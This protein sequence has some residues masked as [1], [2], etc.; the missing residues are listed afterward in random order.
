MN[1]PELLAPIQEFA[2]HRMNSIASSAIHRIQRVN[3]SGAQGGDYDLRT[4]WNEFSWEIQNGDGDFVGGLVEDLVI[5][6]IEGV[7]EQLPDPEA[8]LLTCAFSDDADDVNY[9]DNSVIAAAVLER[10]SDKASLR[11]LERFDP[12]YLW[13]ENL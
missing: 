1:E 3:A 13:Y 2:R 10:V 6:I 9:R 7:V 4:L 11:N 8:V 12:N 5:E